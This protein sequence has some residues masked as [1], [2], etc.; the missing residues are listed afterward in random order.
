MQWLSSS[1]CG[2]FPVSCARWD[3]GAPRTWSQQLLFSLDQPHHS[4]GKTFPTHWPCQVCAL[5]FLH[6]P[7]VFTSGDPKWP[8]I[9]HKAW[10]VHKSQELQGEGET[11]KIWWKLRQR[12]WGKG[13]R[14]GLKSGIKLEWTTGLVFSK[15]RRKGCM[16]IWKIVIHSKMKVSLSCIPKDFLR[17]GKQRINR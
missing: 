17:P 8:T 12:E 3:L 4:E 9:T 1:R 2:N 13:K 15:K 5:T 11:V 6:S 10:A 16:D 7:V 14:E